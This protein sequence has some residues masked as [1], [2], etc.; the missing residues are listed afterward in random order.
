[1]V[2]QKN[3]CKKKKKQEILAQAWLASI[4]AQSLA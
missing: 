2:Y 4:F 1:M 3:I